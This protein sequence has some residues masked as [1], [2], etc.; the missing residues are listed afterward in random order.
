MNGGVL[1]SFAFAFALFAACEAPPPPDDASDAGVLGGDIGDVCSE[2]AD[3]A[4]GL[5]PEFGGGCAVNE[6]ADLGAPCAE[7]ELF[8]TGGSGGRTCEPARERGEQ[9]A[10]FVDCCSDGFR[11]ACAD[12][13]VCGLIFDKAGSGSCVPPTGRAAGEPCGDDVTSCADGLE[14]AENAQVCE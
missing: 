10:S 9:C 4:S 5:C 2:D 7:P 12:G 3:C 11:A 1:L 8:C 6:C 14:C 13:L